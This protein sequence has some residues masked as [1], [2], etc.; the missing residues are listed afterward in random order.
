MIHFLDVFAATTTQKYTILFS[1]PA[2]SPPEIVKFENVPTSF[3]TSP[4]TSINVIFN[5]PIDASTFNHQDMTLRL[6][7]GADIMVGTVMVTEINKTN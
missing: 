3:V 5:K 2:Q 7:A 1:T 6:Q 4:V